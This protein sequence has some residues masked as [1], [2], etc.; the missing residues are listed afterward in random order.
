MGCHLDTSLLQDYLENA[1]G[2]VDKVRI[3]EHLAVCGACRNELA[4]L[5]LLFGGLNALNGNNP[6]IP[7][8]VAAIRE[9]TLNAMLADRHQPMGFKAVLELQ[10]KNIT[11]A[12]IFMK[13][14]PGVQTGQSYLKKGVSRAPAATLA[15]SANILMGSFK[16]LQARFLA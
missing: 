9:K 4:I 15:V 3:E 2:P 11:T 6:E 16:M 5:K 8:E 14:I 12:G 10:R 13:Y 7:P 1:I